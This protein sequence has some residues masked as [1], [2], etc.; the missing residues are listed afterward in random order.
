MSHILVQIYPYKGGSEVEVTHS[1]ILLFSIQNHF[2]LPT[3]KKGAHTG[4]PR[5]YSSNNNF[6]I[7]LI[8]IISQLFTAPDFAPL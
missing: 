2:Q 8:L 6:L 7:Y 1:K 3:K 5:H 4:A